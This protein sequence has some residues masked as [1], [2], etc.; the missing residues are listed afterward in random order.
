VR[1]SGR[2][3][4]GII[5]VATG[6]FSLVLVPAIALGAIVIAMGFVTIAHAAF[7]GPD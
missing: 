5:T 7:A 4:V 3:A 6:V 1:R 2:I